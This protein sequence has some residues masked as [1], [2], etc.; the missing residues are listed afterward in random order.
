MPIKIAA[1]KFTIEEIRAIYRQVEHDWINIKDDEIQTVFK[2]IAQI[3]IEDE[4]V[5]GNSQSAS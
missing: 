1:H 3:V 5:T 2:R 4:L